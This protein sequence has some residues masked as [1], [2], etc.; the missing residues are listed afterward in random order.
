M[1]LSLSLL[2]TGLLLTISRLGKA[3]SS[4]EVLLP[5]GNPREKDGANAPVVV[6]GKTCTLIRSVQDGK[7]NVFMSPTDDKMKS[8]EKGSIRESFV[9]KED[10]DNDTVTS[11]IVRGS[12][13]T[14]REFKVRFHC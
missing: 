5:D 2:A 6:G 12:D 10:K 4:N 14:P 3:S 9:L 13:A 11:F 1:E 8:N 7:S